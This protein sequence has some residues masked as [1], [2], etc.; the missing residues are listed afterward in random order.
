MKRINH[1]GMKVFLSYAR[2]D[3]DEAL[4]LYRALTDAGIAV[5]IDKKDLLPGAPWRS[6]IADAIRSCTFFLV[7]LSTNSVGKRGFVQKEIRIA[8][9][10]VNEMPPSRIFIVPVRLEPCKPNFPILADLNWTDLFPDWDDGIAKL[11]ELFLPCK[12]G[13]SVFDIF[14]SPEAIARNVTDLV[15][16]AKVAK[17]F[18]SSYQILLFLQNCLRAVPSEIK[19]NNMKLQN[20]ERY[21]DDWSRILEWGSGRFETDP[22]TV[23]HMCSGQGT[24]GHWTKE[25]G[26][27]TRS[28]YNDNYFAYC[29]NCLWAYYY[30][31]IDYLGTGPLKFDYEH[32]FYR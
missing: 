14:A 32:N 11:K 1:E 20:L 5:W 30:F 16:L 2:E 24:V 18:S 28:D 26:G 3:L 19:K 6:A 25:G 10:V 13:V 23:C 15:F 4:R 12:E 27:Y 21:I 29:V 17:R 8:I 22:K 7:L 31:E 9:E